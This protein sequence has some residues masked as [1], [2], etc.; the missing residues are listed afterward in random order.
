MKNAMNFF[1]Y[2][3]VTPSGDGRISILSI[4]FHNLKEKPKKKKDYKILDHSGRTYVSKV[5]C[6]K[7]QLNNGRCQEHHAKCKSLY[8]R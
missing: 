6:C 5:P 2:I 8:K 1:L 4:I 7:I 3:M